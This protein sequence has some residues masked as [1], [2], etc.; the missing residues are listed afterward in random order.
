[1]QKIDA[2]TLGVDTET[3]VKVKNFLMIKFNPKLLY[4]WRRQANF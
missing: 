2:S 4:F 1:M 3:A